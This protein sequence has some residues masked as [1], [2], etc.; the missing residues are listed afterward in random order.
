[1]P[2]GEATLPCRILEDPVDHPFYLER[3]EASRSDSPFNTQLYARR[4]F[5]WGVLSY[6][7]TKRFR[8]G[9]GGV[10]DDDL[11]GS[12]LADSLVCDLRLSEEIVARLGSCGGLG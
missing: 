11:E 12:R 3:Y 5:E 1:M 7:G 8:K 6:M 9:P 4:N 2:F 10:T